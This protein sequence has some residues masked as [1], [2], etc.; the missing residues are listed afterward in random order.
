MAGHT[1]RHPVT[2]ARS[3]SRRA[4][5]PRMSGARSPKA[6]RCRRHAPDWICQ[7]AL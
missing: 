6:P 7:R 3:R 4:F 5:R 2:R 1:R